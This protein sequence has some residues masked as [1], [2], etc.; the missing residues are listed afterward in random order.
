[1]RF[2]RIVCCV[3]GAAVVAVYGYITWAIR[4]L[5][6]MCSRFCLVCSISPTNN[7]HMWHEVNRTAVYRTLYRRWSSLGLKV[8]MR[9][10]LRTLVKSALIISRD[11]TPVHRLRLPAALP[12][13]C[14]R[15]ATTHKINYSTGVVLSFFRSREGRV[16][17]CT[18]LRVR[19][20]FE[21]TYPFSA[22]TSRSNYLLLPSTPADPLLLSDPPRKPL[23]LQLAR[24]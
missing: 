15:A 13:C 1:M 2:A 14:A 7:S 24:S 12:T 17:C 21:T 3:Q 8:S 9:C 10:V 16:Y 4:W 5:A 19:L 22:L 18:A 11:W 6:L 23:P 20:V